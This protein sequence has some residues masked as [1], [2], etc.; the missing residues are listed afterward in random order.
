M[1]FA[2]SVLAFAIAWT[3]TMLYLR[4][5]HRLVVQVKSDHRDFWQDTLRAPRWQARH[6]RFGLYFRFRWFMEPV[7]PLLRWLLVGSARELSDE[8]RRRHRAAKRLFLASGLSLAA[9]FVL[10][11]FS[12]G[13]PLAI[14]FT[15]P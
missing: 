5:A 2:A 7:R 12:T 14:R 6:I 1:L 8:T 13:F 10:F 9:T 3:L 11:L 4:A 15:A